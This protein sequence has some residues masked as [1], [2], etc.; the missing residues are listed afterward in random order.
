MKPEQV[1]DVKS[2]TSRSDVFNHVIEHLRKQGTKSLSSVD[3]EMCAYRGEGGAMCAIGVLIAD[4]EYD[5]SFEG[6]TVEHILG[7]N[8][9]TNSLSNRIEPNLEMLIDLQKF[10]DAY[11]QYEDGAF[12]AKAESHINFYRRKWNIE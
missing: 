5:P 1:P 3:K 4:D 11:L 12:T 9:P 7:E 6:K 10:H 2:L 8:L